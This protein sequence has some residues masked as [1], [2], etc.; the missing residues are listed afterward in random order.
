VVLLVPYTSRASGLPTPRPPLTLTA[1]HKK[2]L[3]RGGG[4]KPNDTSERPEHTRF[5]LKGQGGY[6][7][8][9]RPSG[10]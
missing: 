1:K 8:C 10:V 3:Q 2:T 9:Q 5:S 7:G 6:V 4:L